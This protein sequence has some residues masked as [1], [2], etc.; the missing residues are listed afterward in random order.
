MNDIDAC[1]YLFSLYMEQAEILNLEIEFIDILN[2]FLSLG[3]IEEGKIQVH[4]SI[5]TLS[6]VSNGT[7][8]HIGFVICLHTYLENLSSSG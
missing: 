1:R 7:V 6:S 5:F 2:E 4:L 3:K 8:T